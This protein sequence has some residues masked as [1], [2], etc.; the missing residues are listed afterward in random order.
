MRLALT[1]LLLLALA[2]PAAAQQPGPGE[3]DD[4]T[5]ERVRVPMRDGVELNVEMWRPVVPA[6]TKVP[7]ILHL[8]PYHL[9]GVYNTELLPPVEYGG[10]LVRKGYAFAFADVRGTWSSGGCW[11]YGG[12][13]EREDGHD[14]VEWL[15]TRG[16]SNGRVGMIGTSYP[17]TTPNAAAV[18]QP[19]HLATIVPVSGISRW[20]GYAYQQGVRATISG[21]DADVDPPLVTP[22]DFMLGY[23][24]VP[25]P[26]GLLGAPAQV[27]QRWELCDRVTRALQAY[28][29]QP[30][31]DAFWQE[32]DYLRRAD[33]VQVPVLLAHGLQDFNVKTWEGTAW[34]QAIQA[35]KKLVLGQWPHA[36]PGS[37]DE[38]WQD[39]LE[40]WFARWLYE[41]PNG[42]EH[43]PRVRVQGNDGVWRAQHDWG[44]GATTPVAYG[45]GAG[46]FTYYD[47]GLL[48]ESEMLRGL[49]DGLRFKRVALNV[50]AGTRIG[51]RPVVALRAA[52]SQRGTH[53]VATLV[54]RGPGG[55]TAI[56]SRGLLNARYRLGL[57]R[58]VDLV[59]G[60]F[61]THPVEL[62][63]KEWI[64]QPGHRLELLIASANTTWGLSD[65][66]RAV[67]TI[68]LS[69]SRIVLP[70]Y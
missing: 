51:G 40:R 37:H 54:D 21:E 68:D 24:F 70:V 7:V 49:G 64:V 62:I 15:G 27:A 50:P 63:D 10:E 28:D 43:E 29:P 44:P 19:P 39:T 4:F 3:Y 53:F 32:R 59:P 26:T 46:R 66:R 22:P 65:E 16:W 8:T 34:W 55:A 56:V 25:G 36:Y 12:V 9:L 23:G 1:L 42:I 33:R 48:T 58:G 17:G 2:A 31:L 47:D 11:D 18:E 13:K 20:Y 52:S 61:E 38:T 57:E 69:G 35:P 14:L 67:N 60:R 45:L 5:F 30:D 41:V 6:G